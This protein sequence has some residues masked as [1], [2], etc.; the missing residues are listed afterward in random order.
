MVE[1]SGVS[2]ELCGG[3]HAFSTGELGLVK[4]TSE[5]SVAAGVRRIEAITGENA[6]RAFIRSEGILKKAPLFL[7]H[8]RKRLRKN[9]ETRRI[10]KELEKESIH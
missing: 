4:I 6:L 9:Q 8:H 1:V 10:P 5:A 3:T 7:R 2:K